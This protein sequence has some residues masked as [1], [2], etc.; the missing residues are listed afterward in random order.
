MASMNMSLSKLWEIMK[1]REACP[2]GHRE[3]DRTERPNNRN[4]Q[5]KSDRLLCWEA[6]KFNKV[7]SRGRLWR[8]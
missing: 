7:Y 1:D 8:I 6:G 3:S 4:T 5:E 2:R